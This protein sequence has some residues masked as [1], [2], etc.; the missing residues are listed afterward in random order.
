M[1]MNCE[2]C[3]RELPA[4]GLHCLCFSCEARCNS[5]LAYCQCYLQNYGVQEVSTA[6]QVH[7]SSQEVVT[8]RSLLRDNWKEHFYGLSIMLT[9]QRRNTETRSA[10][11]ANAQD[12]A[13]AMDK[14]V[15]LD[16]PPRFIAWDLRCLPMVRPKTTENDTEEKLILLENTLR[17]LEGRVSNNEFSITTIVA[18][19]EGE[20]KP[21]LSD[22][23]NTLK[24]HEKLIQEA[25]PTFAAKAAG[26][27][28][29]LPQT[30]PSPAA[31]TVVVQQPTVQKIAEQMP[32]RTA[33]RR[34]S[35]SRGIST[36][37]N[38]SALLD[39]QQEGRAD[40][41]WQIWKNRRKPRS[42][43][44][45]KG[46]GMDQNIKGRTGGPNRDLWISNIDSSID[47]NDLK[48]FI[49]SGGSTKA[50]QIQIRFWQKRYTDRS[51]SKCFR[52][53][54]GRSDYDKVYNENFWP[55]D[56]EVRKYWLSAE[57]MEASR[58]RNRPQD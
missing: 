39:Q 40:G 22:I 9:G 31:N 42:T 27:L 52:F 20:V 10:Q 4:R 12:I 23:E 54:I 13:T 16:K 15:R 6:I 24:T 21:K 5:L 17:R 46:K 50:G 32:A 44:G 1:A 58:S 18:E 33:V 29:P 53:T 19:N 55:S 25:K 37:N 43:P 48:E 3:E 26:S 45:I 28:P 7:F 8:A 35:G 38:S 30:V 57:E 11:K 34:P 47:D 2:N 51:E 36:K 14:L 49:E 41:D 56:I